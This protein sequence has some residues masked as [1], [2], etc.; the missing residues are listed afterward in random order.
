MYRVA[1][2][3]IRMSREEAAAALHIGIKTLANYEDGRSIPPPEVVLE[4]SRLYNKPLLPH[5]YC[6]T[7]CAIG[8]TYNYAILDN[9]N[10]DIANV[11]LKLVCELEECRAVQDKLLSLAVNKKARQDFTD[12]EWREFIRYLQEYLDIEHTIEMLRFAI[13]GWC[14]SEELIATHNRKCRERGYVIGKGA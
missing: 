9:V 12:T 6:R 10:L 1:R 13:A 7:Y 14:N 11:L 3:E 2:K 5:K 8:Q 4:M